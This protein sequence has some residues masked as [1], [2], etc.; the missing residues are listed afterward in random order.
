MIDF[1]EDYVSFDTMKKMENLFP[2]QLF[3]LNCNQ[4]ECIKIIDFFKELGI[5]NIDDLLV[6][7]IE[8]FFETR[9]DLEDRFLR[10]NV[11]TLV[12]KINNDYMEIDII[13]E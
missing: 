12:E 7:R 2:S 11:P 10:Y 1:L 8:L 13:F 6:N 9:K 4:K 3:N 5:N